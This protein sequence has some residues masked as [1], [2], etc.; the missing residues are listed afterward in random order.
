LI[1]E[2]TE[3]ADL[4]AL[5]SD[6][7]E[8][9]HDFEIDLNCLVVMNHR[10]T[11]QGIDREED[12]Q[13]EMIGGSKSQND[14]EAV[15]SLQSWLQ[16]QYD[17]LRRSANNQAAVALVTRVQHWIGR[18]AKKI[19]G[20]PKREESKLISE[21]NHL[22]EYVSEGPVPVAF[23]TDLVNVRD[24]LIHGDSKAEWDD[25][26]G[27]RRRV[28]DCYKNAYPD[29]QVSEA[30]LA[31]AIA[32]ATQLVKC[33]TTKY[34]VRA[35]VS[36]L[37]PISADRGS[38]GD[39]REGAV[40]GMS[41]ISRGD[42]ICFVVVLCHLGLELEIAAIK[43]KRKNICAF[44]PYSLDDRVGLDNPFTYHAGGLRHVRSKYRVG[45][46]MWEVPEVR[47]KSVVQFERPANLKGAVQIYLSGD[48]LGQ[49]RGLMPKGTGKGEPILLDGEKAG[50]REGP[51]VVKI[52]AVDP[53]NEACVPVAPDAGARVLN[54][55]KV[56]DPW[57][58]VQV[59]QPKDDARLRQAPRSETPTPAGFE[60]HPT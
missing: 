19:P 17:D 10:F 7:F 42:G 9:P 29:T 53:G 20:K 45:D 54:F 38:V 6:L 22:N 33:Y 15:R 51:S 27:I 43:V 48:P 59:Y 18:L 31:E 3:M 50:F 34:A 46:K 24:S 44:T 5:E 28:A 57:I 56:T 36:P 35:P 52:Y 30:Q 37:Q 13:L 21:L 8:I 58:A 55:I 26:H 40:V 4:D 1:F 14:Q 2:G 12:E 32:K 49:F 47:E 39:G 11:L 16:G 25:H 60:A 23:F 41:A